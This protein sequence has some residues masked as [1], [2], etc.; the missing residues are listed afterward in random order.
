MGIAIEENMC[1]NIFKYQLRRVHMKRNPGYTLQYIGGTCYLLPYGQL[2]AD[3]RLGSSLNSTGELIWELLGRE[4]SREELHSELI[5]R[6]MPEPDQKD[7]LLEDI[8]QFLEQLICGGFIKDDAMPV[9]GAEQPCAYLGIGG[10]TL[11]FCG[12]REMIEASFL[13]EFCI[14]PNGNEDQRIAVTWGNI[15]YATGGKIIVRNDELIICE[16][17]KDYVLIFPTYSQLREVELS[18]D[19]KIAVFRCVPPSTEKLHEEFFHAL[20]HVYL[21]LAEKHRMH[22]IHS[23]SICYEGKAWLFSASAGTGKSTHTNMWRELYNTELLNGDLNLLAIENGTP[24]VHGIPWCGTSEIFTKKTV[25]L[26]GIVMLRRG[27]KDAIET[28][29]PDKQALLVMQRF[30]SPMW[31]VDQLKES[32]RFA[33]EL[34][35]KILVCRLRCTKNISAAELSKGMIDNELQKRK[36]VGLG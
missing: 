24:V 35:G 28:L 3:H 17:D 19:G 31:T 1:Y 8:D 27:G 6:F 22:A 20:R 23:A 16:R 30:I 33:E 21:Y 9:S 34:T 2:I 26:G 12:P 15:G 10:L 4:I 18:K 13:K 5:E 11:A 7:E 25:P 14:T 36:T 32:V 29:R